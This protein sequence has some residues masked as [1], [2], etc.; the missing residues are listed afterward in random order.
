MGEALDL[1]MDGKSPY[2]DKST[3]I[4]ADTPDTDR[5]V[6]AAAADGQSAVVVSADGDTRTLSPE[7]ILGSDAVDAA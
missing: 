6:K 1:A 3:F 7:E 2:P 4:D 5:E